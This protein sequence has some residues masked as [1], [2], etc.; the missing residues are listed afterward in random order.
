MAIICV[1]STE[2]G[3]GKSTLALHLAQG[4][5]ITGLSTVLVDFSDDCSI[6]RA[7]EIEPGDNPSAS[8]LIEARGELEKVPANVV[9]ED[10]RENLDVLAASPQLARTVRRLYAP[11]RE[12]MLVSAFHQLATAYDCV[13]VDTSPRLNLLTRCCLFSADIVVYPVTPSLV[14]AEGLQSFLAL[15]EYFNLNPIWCV[16]RTMRRRGVTTQSTEL[17]QLLETL[18][19][20]RLS[21]IP[22]DD[23]FIENLPDIRLLDTLLCQ[24]KTTENATLFDTNSRGKQHLAA[25]EDYMS[26]VEEIQAVSEALDSSRQQ[27]REEIIAPRRVRA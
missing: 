13:V 22:A 5:A 27:P 25:I 4:S 12:Y 1:A 24:H 14:S 6:T 3:V 23:D 20:R 15:S 21:D 19:E 9:T 26:L 17:Q 16:A 11:D 2:S 8:S 18:R 7:L 10:V